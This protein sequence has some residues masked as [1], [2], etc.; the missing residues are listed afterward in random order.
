MEKDASMNV[1]AMIIYCIKFYK[2]IK[3]CALEMVPKLALAFS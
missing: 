1:L 2:M 3:Y